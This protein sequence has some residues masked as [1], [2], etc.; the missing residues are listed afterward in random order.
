MA[1]EVKEESKV[2]KGSKKR[3]LIFLLIGFL[4]IGI[5]GSGVFLILGKKGEEPEGEGSPKKEKKV[6]KSKDTI[7][8]VMDPVIVNLMDPTGKRYFQVRISL[9]VPTKKEEDELK[10]KEPLIRDRILTILSSKTVEE[11]IAPDAKDKIKEQI[12]KKLNEE[13]GEDMI[14]GVYITQYVVE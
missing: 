7:F 1:E 5:A 8:I 4:I 10:K 11:V 2:A 9:E 12:L 3:L 13:L 6:R 14:L